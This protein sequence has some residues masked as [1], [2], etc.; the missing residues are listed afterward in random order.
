MS[1]LKELRVAK[2]MTQEQL[3]DR[4]GCHFSTI[5][6]LETGKQQLTTTW[7]DKLAR[8]LGVSA[9]ELLA[10]SE[11]ALNGKGERKLGG[12]FVRGVVQ[13]GQW[14]EQPEWDPSDWYLMTVPVDGKS[15]ADRRFG[16]EVKGPSMNLLYPEGS[17]LI[18]EQIVSADTYPEPG[19]RYIVQRRDAGG[20]YETTVKEMRMDRAG[21]AWLW[22]RSDDPEFQEPIE[23]IGD[24][25][26]EI[27]IAAVVKQCIRPDSD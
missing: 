23:V 5:N 19:Q 8:G 11:T 16:V 25:L 17:I 9:A 1:R 12:V 14:S 22:P 13:A 3:G 18:C 27:K 10:D 15:R 24:E 21:R 26:T 4:A 20:K 7:L 6:K 2:G